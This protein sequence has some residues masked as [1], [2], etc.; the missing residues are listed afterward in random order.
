MHTSV[1]MDQ[2]FLAGKLR[3]WN[4]LRWHARKA[5]LKLRKCEQCLLLLYAW[6]FVYNHLLLNPRW[7]QGLMWVFMCSIYKLHDEAKDKAFELEMS[8]ICEESKREHQKVVLIYISAA[9]W[10]FQKEVN[11]KIWSH[12]RSLMI[13][14]RKQRR[15]LKLHSRRWMLTKLRKW[16]KL[17]MCYASFGVSVVKL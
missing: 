15:Q 8:W 1:L 13:F 4:Y 3:N 14:W 10:W 2:G 6:W 5:L 9:Y 7:L 11:L 12:R 16:V 17:D